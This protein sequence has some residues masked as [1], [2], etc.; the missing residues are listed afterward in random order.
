MNQHLSWF[1]M[2]EQTSR[3]RNLLSL[4]LQR[5]LGGRRRFFLITSM[6]HQ[7]LNDP[8]SFYGTVLPFSGTVCTM[9][10]RMQY[11]NTYCVAACTVPPRT[12]CIQYQQPLP[13]RPL[14]RVSC[15][16][17]LSQHFQNNLKTTPH[18]HYCTTVHKMYK[19]LTL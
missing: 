15:N 12:Q 8:P 13:L 10:T 7:L 17:L 11:K 6:S 14:E 3:R 16:L 1:K 4:K 18:S 9:Y 5:R 19:Y 2:S